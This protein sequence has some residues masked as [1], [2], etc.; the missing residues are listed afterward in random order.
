MQD[1][2]KDCIY[3]YANCN[4]IFLIKKILKIIYKSEAKENKNILIVIII[5]IYLFFINLLFFVR[6][7]I[8]N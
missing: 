6:F 2:T 8:C 3:N 1:N 4:L 7:I 5:I